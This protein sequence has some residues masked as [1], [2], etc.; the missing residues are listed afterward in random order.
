MF[1]KMVAERGKQ[2]IRWCYAWYCSGNSIILKRFS[3]GKW[4]A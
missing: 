4:L 3:V 1:A 2:F